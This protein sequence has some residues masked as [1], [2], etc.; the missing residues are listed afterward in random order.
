MVQVA[1]SRWFGECRSVSRV[2]FTTFL[3]VVFAL[4]V[5]DRMAL[6]GIFGSILGSDRANSSFHEVREADM[7]KSEY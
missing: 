3:T 6:F 4:V 5:L 7:W 2:S 1:G